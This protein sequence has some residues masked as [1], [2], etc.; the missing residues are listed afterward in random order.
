MKMPEKR[1]YDTRFFMEYFYTKDKT[2]LSELKQELT[3][4]KIKMVSVLTIHEMHR[5][6]MRYEGKE[7]ATI[8]SSILRRD[9]TVVDVNYENAVLSAQLRSKNNMP[10]ADSIIATAAQ[11]YGCT[12]VSDDAHFKGIP[13]LKTK[14]FN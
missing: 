5:F 13:N 10:M 7:V 11:T 14:W 3:S 2:L 9:F 8:R 4:A 1:F 6:D 12:L